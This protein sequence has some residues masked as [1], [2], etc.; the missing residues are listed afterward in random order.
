MREEDRYSNEKVR[1]EEK[2]NRWVSGKVEMARE[3]VK[4]EEMEGD[5]VRKE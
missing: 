5:K 2:Y 1:K 3:R 4:K